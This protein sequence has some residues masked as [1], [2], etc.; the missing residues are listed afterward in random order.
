[1]IETGSAALNSTGW[2]FIDYPSEANLVWLADQFGKP[3]PSR[4]DGPLLNL[5]TPRT[6]VTARANTLSSRCGFGPFPFHTDAAH[7]PTPP[8]LAFLRQRSRQKTS[9]PTLVTDVLGRA[10]MQERRLLSDCVWVVN[11][12]RGAFYTSI[13]ATSP[14]GDCLRYDSYCM[15]PAH[16]RFAKVEGLVQE[17]IA[18]GPVYKIGWRPNKV[19]ILDN[20]RVLHARGEVTAENSERVLE[21][22]LAI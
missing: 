15:R 8:R 10:T 11:G 18:A 6:A 9:T 13:L 21:R 19:L 22:V 20:W 4:R 3:V 7:F 14:R 5:L 16:D 2:A 12:G 1:M 17:M